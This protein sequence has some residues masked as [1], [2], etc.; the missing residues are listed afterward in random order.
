MDLGDW[1]DDIERY[2]EENFPEGVHIPINVS[3]ET[4]IRSVQEQF[5]QSGFECPG[6]IARR[7]VR[8]GWRTP[9]SSTWAVR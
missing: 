4:A 1:G 2:I 7:L 3:E 8:E 5:Q 6:D 9:R